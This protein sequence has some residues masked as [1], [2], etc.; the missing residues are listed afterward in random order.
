MLKKL[1]SILFI[2]MW[3]AGLCT[4]FLYIQCDGGFEQHSTNQEKLSIT[5]N[6][7]KN[8]NHNNLQKNKGKHKT[9]QTTNKGGTLVTK[10]MYV[11]KQHTNISPTSSTPVNQPGSSPRQK[12][13]YKS[14]PA[15]NSLP[16]IKP[17]QVTPVEDEQSLQAENTPAEISRQS[18]RPT[19]EMDRLLKQYNTNQE[20]SPIQIANTPKPLQHNKPKEDKKNPKPNQP[21]KNQGTSVAKNMS[22][23]K[24]NN[25]PAITPPSTN[26]PASSSKQESKKHKKKDFPQQDKPKNA[27]QKP[28]HKLSLVNNSLAKI[29]PLQVT[30]KEDLENLRAEIR[31]TEEAGQLLKAAQQMDRLLKMVS[32]PTLEDLCYALDLNH[33]APFVESRKNRPHQLADLIAEYL[34]IDPQASTI[35]FKTHSWRQLRPYLDYLI[36]ETAADSSYEKRTFKYKSEGKDSN[37]HYEWFDTHMQSY[38]YP[39]AIGGGNHGAEGNRSE[40]GVWDIYHKEITINNYTQKETESRESFAYHFHGGSLD[41]DKINPTTFYNLMVRAGFTEEDFEEGKYGFQDKVLVK[42]IILTKHTPEECNEELRMNVVST[43]MQSKHPYVALIFGLQPDVTFTISELY[44]HKLG[45]YFAKKFGGTAATIIETQE[46]RLYLCFYNA[47]QNTLDLHGASL[48]EAFNKLHSFILKRYNNFD[49]E[50]TVIT[51]RG[52]HIN[53]NG[54]AGIL[55]KSFK[56]WAKN[57]LKEYIKSYIPM[58]GNGGYKI[59]LCKPVKVVLTNQS[60][61]VNLQQL[62][63][64]IL[65]ADQ[66]NNK[67]LIITHQQVQPESYYAKLLVSLLHELAEKHSFSIEFQFKNVEN[68]MQLSW[69]QE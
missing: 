56:G 27:N 32:R 4:I 16:K 59:V 62:A 47:T 52:N 19:Q 40:K 6:T 2:N 58:A 1:Q 18:L 20:R 60:P 30:S 29:K 25:I 9:N 63:A 35:C 46:N 23:L 37:L 10:N 67:R 3:L 42:P 24:T 11:P 7:A 14:S 53:P 54:Q 8:S 34:E 41:T 13:S 43:L 21:S 69:E 39:I 50:C 12:P 68:G 26:Q 49:T 15:N 44:R 36:A 17:A 57:A 64:A 66:T 61:E 22:K 48:E 65:K 45:Q 31:A 55:N 5:T 33:R 38:K 51:G 28:P